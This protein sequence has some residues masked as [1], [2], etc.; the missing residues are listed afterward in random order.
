VQTWKFH[1]RWKRRAINVGR[2]DKR[3]EM[4]RIARGRE[5]ISEADV[6]M[7]GSTRPQLIALL[8]E[9]GIEPAASAALS[10]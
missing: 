4:L 10:D 1:Y 9:A 8:H 5:S 2:I 3:M 6:R 7:Y